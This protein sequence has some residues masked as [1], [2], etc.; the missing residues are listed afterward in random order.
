MGQ[1]VNRSLRL[2]RDGV[3]AVSAVLLALVIASKLDQDNRIR[4]TGRF[5]AV[6]GDTLAQGNQRFRLEG[7]DAPEIAQ[8]CGVEPA[9]DPCGSSA[10]ARLAAFVSEPSFSCSGGG[11]DRY[12][13][14][15]V[16]C[17]ADGLDVNRAMVRE[18]LAVA[19]GDYGGEEAAAREEGLGIWSGPFDRPSDWRRIH[20]AG[21]EETEH[22]SGLFA[23]LRRWLGIN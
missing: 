13:R 20:R 14:Q 23:L 7:I 6:D 18:G 22:A 5:V 11:V 9:V 4:L 15:L 3:V 21:M 12:G 1:I 16:R 10:R 2:L 8:T 19:Y 17:V